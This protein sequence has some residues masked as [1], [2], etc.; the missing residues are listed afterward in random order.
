[1]DDIQLGV[2]PEPSTL[3]ILGLGLTGLGLLGGPA[4]RARRCATRT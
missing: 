2:I 1:M 4:T 3:A